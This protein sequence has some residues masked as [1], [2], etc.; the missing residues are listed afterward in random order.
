[1]HDL[2]WRQK[3][4]HFCNS[5]VYFNCITNSYHRYFNYH[6]NIS[7]VTPTLLQGGGLGILFNMYFSDTYLMQVVHGQGWW[8]AQ[9]VQH[10]ALL[11]PTPPSRQFWSKQKPG[12]VSVVCVPW[13]AAWI[14]SPAGIGLMA[15][16]CALW[17]LLAGH[18]RSGLHAWAVNWD[19]VKNHLI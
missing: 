8:Y 10:Q 11:K 15:C 12:R 16:P 4:K 17:E 7:I 18:G 19:R 5:L 14:P 2:T 1:M 3:L 6:N 13:A 9:M